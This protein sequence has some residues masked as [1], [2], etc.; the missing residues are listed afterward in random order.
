MSAEAVRHHLMGSDAGPPRESGYGSPTEHDVGSSPPPASPGPGHVDGGLT[1][2]R[3]GQPDGKCS[4]STEHRTAFVSDGHYRGMTD[5]DIRGFLDG[6]FVY[7]WNQAG[8]QHVR[9]GR[10]SWKR[11]AP[12]YGEPELFRCLHRWSDLHL[13]P[14][15]EV[16]RARLS[17]TIESAA[18]TPVE[19]FLYPVNKEWG[20]GQGGELGDNTSPP[21]KGEVWWRAAAAGEREW[22]LPGAGFRSE[23][24]EDRDTAVM[25]LADDSCSPGDTSL[26]FCSARLTRYVNRRVSGSRPCLF[27]LKLDDRGEDVPD[28]VIELYSAEHGEPGAPARRPEL[29]LDWT[30][31]AALTRVNEI[32]LERGRQITLPAVECRPG[33]WMAA[34]FRPGGASATPLLEVR[35]ELGGELTG[36]RE[37]RHPF[38]VRGKR[39]IFRARA[40]RNPVELGDPFAATIRDTWVT[41]GPEESRS[42]RWRFWSPSGAEHEVSASYLGDYQWQVRFTPEEV[43]RWVYSWEHDFTPDP[44]DPAAG[45][46]DVVADELSALLEALRSLH[47]E[48]S[49]GIDQGGPHARQRLGRKLM[50]L[51]RAVMASMSPERW[52]DAEGQ[53]VRAILRRIR[54]LLWGRPIPENLPLEA[55]ARPWKRDDGREVGQRD[56]SDIQR[57]GFISRILRRAGR[58]LAGRLRR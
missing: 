48:V 32:H 12:R 4:E 28:S 25:P 47:D 53:E 10:E 50:N 29:L 6:T 13:P 3:F 30:C 26:S 11:P 19:V 31:D 35:E 45:A 34:T 39:I 33:D 44:Y 2:S 18:E 54:S 52:R 55:H 27:M 43:G 42:V 24:R 41:T 17:V 21:G 9:V 1:I 46:F 5:N 56:R 22:A 15:A 58:A 36:W 51:Q 8:Q 37:V 23:D 20:P 7:G 40:V 14:E 38:Q 49:A 16:V 57:H